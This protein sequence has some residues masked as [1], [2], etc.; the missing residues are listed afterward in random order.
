MEKESPKGKKNKRTVTSPREIKIKVRKNNLNNSSNTQ[1]GTPHDRSKYSSQSEE[2]LFIESP[3]VSDT[4]G[5]AKSFFGIPIAIDASIRYLTNCFTHNSKYTKQVSEWSKEEVIEFFDFENLQ[6]VSTMINNDTLKINDLFQYTREQFLKLGLSI[7]QVHKVTHVLEQLRCFPLFFHHIKE[8]SIFNESDAQQAS[9]ILSKF[10][11]S[12]SVCLFQEASPFV[13]FLL[14]KYYFITNPLPFFCEKFI[15]EIENNLESWNDN[16]KDIPLEVTQQRDIRMIFREYLDN[17][18]SNI[19]QKLIETMVEITKTTTTSEKRDC[20]SFFFNCFSVNY[21][22]GVRLPLLVNFFYSSN[23]TEKLVLFDSEDIYEGEV[24]KHLIQNVRC[25]LSVITDPVS[26]DEVSVPGKLAVTT[27]RVMFIP[28]VKLDVQ[29]RALLGRIGQCP[30][31]NIVDKKSFQL[32]SHPTEYTLRIITTTYFVL[33]FF[34]YDDSFTSVETAIDDVILDGIPFANRTTEMGH[35]PSFDNVFQLEVERMNIS[36]IITNTNPDVIPFGAPLF[37]STLV[38]TEDKKRKFVISYKHKDTNS[39]LIRLSASSLFNTNTN[40]TLMHEDNNIF[41]MIE[42]N[43]LGIELLEKTFI[44]LQEYCSFNKELPYYRVYTEKVG[45]VNSFVNALMKTVNSVITLLT[46]DNTNILLLPKNLKEMDV[47]V[48]CSLVQI[49]CDPFFRTIDGFIRLIQKELTLFK[50]DFNSSRFVFTILIVV[51]LLLNKQFPTLFQFNETFIFFIHHHST[52]KLFK[53]FNI[54]DASSLEYFINSNRDD[55]INVFYEKYHGVFPPSNFTTHVCNEMF[56][57]IRTY[58]SQI[59]SR[60][61]QTTHNGELEVPNLSIHYF[62]LQES[63][64]IL[65]N[66]TLLNLSHNE[67]VNF[68]TDVAK[69]TSLKQ[70]NLSHNKLITISHIISNLQNLTN[71]NLSNNIINA[72]PESLT[73]IG[74]T[75]LDISENEIQKSSQLFL[76]ASLQSLCLRSVFFF[77]SI[78]NIQLTYLDIS[79]TVGIEDS[80]AHSLPP[81]SLLELSLSNCFIEHL[82]QN[83]GKLTKLT[84]IDISSNLLTSL[85]PFFFSLTNLKSVN[86]TKNPLPQL[87]VMISKLVSLTQLQLEQSVCVP[88]SLRSLYPSHISKDKSNKKLHDEP[89]NVILTGDVAK[90]DIFV[91]LAKKSGKERDVENYSFNLDK[92]III[93]ETPYELIEENPFAISKKSHIFNESGILKGDSNIEERLE[94]NYPTLSITH[95]DYSVNGKEKQIKELLKLIKSL[96][97]QF[98]ISIPQNSSKLIEELQYV[99]LFPGIVETDTLKLL[100]DGLNIEK[101]QQTNTFTILQKLQHI[102]FFPSSYSSSFGC[103]TTHYLS[104]RPHRNHFSMLSLTLPDLVTQHLLNNTTPTGIIHPDSFLHQLHYLSPEQQDYLLHTRSP[105]L[106]PVDNSNQY[107]PYKSPRSSRIDSVD[108][109]HTTSK[110]LVLNYCGISQDRFDWGEPTLNEMEI[111]R[112]YRLNRLPTQ[113]GM[114]LISILSVKYTVTQAWRTGLLASITTIK[115]K[116]QLFVEWD[117][118]KLRIVFRIRFNIKNIETFLDTGKIWND[119]TLAIDKMFKYFPQVTYTYEILCPHCIKNGQRID[120]CY[121]IDEEDILTTIGCGLYVDS[122]AKHTIQFAVN[123]WDILSNVLYLKQHEIE[124]KNISFIETLKHGSSSKVNICKLKGYEQPVVV[125]Q[126]EMDLEGMLMNG[127]DCVEYYTERVDDFLRETEFADFPVS[128]N[129]AKVIGFCLNPL[130]I[131]MEYFNGGN[132]FDYIANTATIPWKDRISIALNIAKG[133]VFLNSQQNPII[134]RDLKSPNVILKVD[135]EK[136]ITQVAVTDFG[137]SVPI[138]VLN[139]K[140]SHCV[141]CPFWLAPE[142]IITQNYEIESDIYSFGMILWELSTLS[143]PFPQFNFMEEV[144]EFVK[145][146]KLQKIPQSPYPEFDALIQDCWKPYKERPAFGSIVVRL[147]KIYDQVKKL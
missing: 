61:L 14:I 51:L 88:Y 139:Y 123:C 122:Y 33:T 49:L 74:L 56:Y 86:L 62:P 12:Q 44:E 69:C 121:C 23:Q 75:H 4:L 58:S 35:I 105:R 116:Y 36:N 16:K 145:S 80:M 38:C 98:H 114:M 5:P 1:P 73:T 70:L 48:F 55:F 92:N 103:F 76:P 47:G 95:F 91:S 25:P 142:A 90:T 17:E 32:N 102:F 141:E 147:T 22:F 8:G 132:L 45:K 63:F 46:T 108:R 28:T 67:L 128:P 110:V 82:P 96:S 79:N 53:D 43:L 19:F 89:I 101:D 137:Q 3:R 133:M 21:S 39:Q 146:G 138:S 87:S 109:R 60:F 66:L 83:L 104:A 20:Y 112:C 84:Q 11:N 10:K 13:V 7:F 143:A 34:S 106:Q 119:I 115:N 24:I 97:D 9:N 72:L 18:E 135:S 81:I 118:D 144:R 140:N 15:E 52:S 136:N 41:K 59:I 125:K 111:G 29:R 93:T 6:T 100:M 30:L 129:I 65:T 57:Q 71:L 126:L 68:P 64:P 117:F 54:T 134:H 107:S 124:G 37:N 42:V 94:S 78:A 31:T 131:V 77:P 40:L 127:D 50:Y 99:D 113:I 120:E 2:K 85:P 27:Y 130:G 26:S